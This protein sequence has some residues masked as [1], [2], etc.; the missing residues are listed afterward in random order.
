[1]SQSNQ[2][3]FHPTPQSVQQVA[4]NPTPSNTSE[5]YLILQ[6]TQS[7]QKQNQMSKMLQSKDQRI[8]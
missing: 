7:N 1:M 2:K 4:Y 3:P 8:K 5:K 6:L